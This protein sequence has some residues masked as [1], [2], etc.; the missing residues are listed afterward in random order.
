MANQ[1]T[2]KNKFRKTKKI[3]KQWKTLGSNKF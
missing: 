2:G 1:S 3:E